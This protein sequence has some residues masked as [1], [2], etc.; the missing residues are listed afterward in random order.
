MGEKSLSLVMRYFLPCNLTNGSTEKETEN[1]KTQADHEAEDK[2]SW[3]IV[4]NPFHLGV[5]APPKSTSR[6]E[7]TNSTIVPEQSLSNTFPANLTDAIPEVNPWLATAYKKPKQTSE[8]RIEKLQA[9]R[10]RAPS[11]PD[12]AQ[13]NV[14]LATL[15]EKLAGL[16]NQSDEEDGPGMQYG[17]GKLAFQQ[18]ELISRAFAGDALEGDFEKEKEAAIAEDAPREEDLTMPGWGAWT[19]KGVKRPRVERKLVKKIP[20][21]D[22]SKRKDAKLNNVIIN[23]KVPKKVPSLPQFPSSQARTC[24]HV[25]HRLL[26][27]FLLVGC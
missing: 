17:R 27:C 26:L 7:P 2:I 11:T 15:N 12:S 14:D 20:G 13:I 9:K 19:G 10:K 21:I 6:T 3:R 22:A 25:P 23:E 5:K 18:A 4:K 24:R 16:Q 8:N 1:P